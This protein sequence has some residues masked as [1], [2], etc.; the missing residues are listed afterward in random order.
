MRVL[1]NCFALIL[2]TL[3]IVSAPSLAPDTWL[4]PQYGLAGVKLPVVSVQGM[5]N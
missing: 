3:T 1:P 2:I 4:K 5:S